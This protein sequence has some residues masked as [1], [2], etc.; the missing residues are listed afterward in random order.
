M[1]GA[2][3]AFA[4]EHCAAPFLMT[5]A[6]LLFL[7]QAASAF[8]SALPNAG[9]ANIVVAI[10][11]S[12]TMQVCRTAVPAWMCLASKAWCFSPAPQILQKLPNL[13]LLVPPHRFFGAM[14]ELPLPKT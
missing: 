3:S 9:C 7:T 4:S 1:R 8:Q 2:T 12:P 13:E 6:T 14:H 11:V 10:S 5:L